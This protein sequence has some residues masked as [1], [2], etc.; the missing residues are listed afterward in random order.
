MTILRKPMLRRFTAALAFISLAINTAYANSSQVGIAPVAR[1]T[2]KESIL[3]AV[4]TLI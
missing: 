3:F 4:V 1:T 2:L